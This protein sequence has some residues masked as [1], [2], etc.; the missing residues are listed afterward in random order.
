L[1]SLSIFE[2]VRVPLPHGV[3]VLRKVL[4]LVAMKET[5]GVHD[6]HVLDRV[7]VGTLLLFCFVGGSHEVPLA[8]FVLPPRGR[9]GIVVVPLS[10]LLLALML[11]DV[12]VDYFVT[13]FCLPL[14]LSTF[15]LTTSSLLA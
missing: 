2:G 12:S 5:W 1:S 14:C 4:D 13:A 7:V 10:R 3:V 9:G 6:V 11:V 8:L 15:T